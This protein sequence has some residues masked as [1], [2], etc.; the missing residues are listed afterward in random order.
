MKK[1]FRTVTCLLMFTA[2]F[3]GVAC[4]TKEAASTVAAPDNS[5]KTMAE[6]ITGIQPELA[7]ASLYMDEHLLYEETHNA[8]EI[9][10]EIEKDVNEYLT[11]VFFT[12]DSNDGSYYYG[13]PFSVENA[14]N[15]LSCLWGIESFDETTLS[16]VPTGAYGLIY[17]PETKE[18]K[19]YCQDESIYYSHLESDGVAEDKVRYAATAM[20]GN[21]SEEYCF[22]HGV[23]YFSFEYADNAYGITVKEVL[24]RGLE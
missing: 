15:H 21:P 5:G 9:K 20:D 17:D 7:G 22:Y 11:S 6:Y 10:A 8:S 14:K 23:V 16:D 4:K 3:A 13:K 24:I 2:L 19:A 12:A 1:L 18:L